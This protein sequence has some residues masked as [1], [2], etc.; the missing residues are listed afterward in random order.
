LVGA[1][2]VFLTAGILL[3]ACFMF[4]RRLWLPMGV[5]FAWNFTQSGI[6]GLSVSGNKALPGLLKA[7]LYG[8]AWLT[9]GEFGP[10]ASA[11][12]VLLG[13]LLGVIILKRAVQRGRLVSAPWAR[14]HT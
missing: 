2:A 13:L 14:K 5:H 12:T 9:G 6:F 8:P 3:A 7:A 4:T 1:L 10:E 11:V